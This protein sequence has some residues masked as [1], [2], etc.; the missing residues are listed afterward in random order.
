MQFLF[1]FFDLLTRVCLLAA[2]GLLLSTAIFAQTQ[3]PAE[4]QKW[5]SRSQPDDFAGKVW[6]RIKVDSSEPLRYAAVVDCETNPFKP[7]RWA[8]GTLS[9]DGLFTLPWQKELDNHWPKPVAWIEPADGGWLTEGRFTVWAELPV[10]KR[11]QWHCAV[12]LRAPGRRNFVEA[13]TTIEFASAPRP[14]AIFKR[15]S[16]FPDD[17]GTV[18]F[19]MPV[20]GG[21]EGLVSLKTFSEWAKERRTLVERLVKDPT[22]QPE[23]IKI[24]TWVSFKNY[25]KGGGAARPEIAELDFRNLHDLGLNGIGPTVLSDDLFGLLAEK[26]G[27]RGTMLKA[28]AT[29]MGGFIRRG[30]GK[31]DYRPGETAE[32]RWERVF[33]DYYSRRAEKMRKDEPNLYRLTDHVI[34]G[35]EITGAVRPDRLANDPDILGLYR[36]WLERNGIT[37]SELGYSRWDQVMPAHEREKLAE[38]DLR[39]SKNF[40]YTRRFINHYTEAYYRSATKAVERHFPQADLIA[41]NYQAGPMQFGFIGSDNNLDRGQL[42]IFE[43]GRNRAFKGAMTE[44]WVKGWDLGIGREM[45]GAGVIRAS[46]RKHDL[47]L[48]G[49]LVGGEAIRA[50]MIGYVSQGIKEINMYQYGPITNKGPAWADRPES[51]RQTADA[52]AIIGKFDKEIAAG[53]LKKPRAAMLV[54]TAYDIMQ[55][56]GTHLIPERQDLF[57]ALAHSQIPVDLISEQEIL[58]ENILRD[59]S[60]LYVV[61]PQSPD[62]VQEEIAKWVRAGGWL[63]A[64]AGAL[65]YDEFGRPS[66]RMEEVFGV[67]NLKVVEQ[68]EGIKPAA[69]PWTAKVNRFDLKEV[70]KLQLEGGIFEHPVLLDVRGVKL[71]SSRSRAKVIGRYTDGTPGAFENDFG[72][73]KGILIG[74]LVGNAYLNANY[75]GNPDGNDELGENWRSGL[76]SETANAAVVPAEALGGRFFRLSV[77]GVYATL[78]ESGGN[79][80]IFLNNA[81]GR[82]VPE[83]TVSM[84]FG[85]KR[86]TVESARGSGVTYRGPDSFSI[87]LDN[88]DILLIRRDQ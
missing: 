62:E 51:L 29:G 16:E 72:K 70:D 81:S 17:R 82:P 46:A 74:A 88:A 87:P 44:D 43:L 37:A 53:R 8:V 68:P 42:D 60:I 3:Y 83:I 47:P 58:E 33:E 13:A 40:Y 9:A 48:A 45:F 6:I 15:V 52:I 78:M 2:A 14:D 10:S 25:R 35:D 26:Y 23:G 67:S 73:G 21:V 79:T 71:V 49:Y 24:R 38:G 85:I 32:D 57:V 65:M 19:R 18:S 39:Y 56:G 64:S 63:W 5:L 69:P 11:N 7:A 31:Y 1:S 4:I 41:V 61:D 86:G 30:R 66:K 55:T 76:G 80:I 12:S 36:R 50:E 54:S 22:R 27:M 59:Y 20:K 77:N 84:G 28:W 75:P 34:L